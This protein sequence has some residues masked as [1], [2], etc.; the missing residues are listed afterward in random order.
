MQYFYIDIPTVHYT[1]IQYFIIMI[2]CSL[3]YHVRDRVH[4]HVIVRIRVRLNIINVIVQR[5]LCYC[6]GSVRW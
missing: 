3:K 1:S 4:G 6:V 2:M 5:Y